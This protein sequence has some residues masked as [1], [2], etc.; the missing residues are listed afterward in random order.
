MKYEYEFDLNPPI[1]IPPVFLAVI[2]E[3]SD[4]SFLF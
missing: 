4:Q 2:D 1:G 3:F